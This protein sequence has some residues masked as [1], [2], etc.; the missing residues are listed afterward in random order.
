M[1]TATKVEGGTHEF[2]DG[3]VST[4]EG[5]TRRARCR[6]SAS[7]GGN[8]CSVAWMPLARHLCS[9]CLSIGLQIARRITAKHRGPDAAGADLQA[10]DL[11]PG[12]CF[13]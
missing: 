9:I 13:R 2:M 3:K 10:A 4:G 7:E 1:A 12:Y 5:Q 6:S 8:C 11:G